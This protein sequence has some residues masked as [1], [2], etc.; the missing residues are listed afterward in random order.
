VIVSWAAFFINVKVL[1]PRIAVGFISLLTLN[2]MQGSFVGGLPSVPYLTWAEVFF[3]CHRFFMISQLFETS[4]ASFIC[5]NVSFRVGRRLDIFARIVVPLDYCLMIILLFA[6]GT[7]DAS[8]HERYKKLLNG[9]LIIVAINMLMLIATFVGWTVYNY[10][11]LAMRMRR[12][13]MALHRKTFNPPLDPNEAGMMFAAISDED[14]IAS[15][16]EL[17][18]Q[19]AEHS[20]VFT[21]EELLKELANLSPS[22]QPIADQVIPMALEC[23]KKRTIIANLRLIDANLFRIHFKVILDSLAVYMMR[24]EK[25]KSKG[26]NFMFRQKTSS[27]DG[28]KARTG[29][30]QVAPYAP[31]PQVQ[32]ALQSV[33]V[34]GAP[35]ATP[36]AAPEVDDE[37][38]AEE[39][40]EEGGKGAYEDIADPDSRADY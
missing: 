10:K 22:L 38:Q 15:W 12:D 36:A 27:I 18:R 5:D 28:G 34:Q 19:S 13:P 17:F 24:Q 35:S 23:L 2:N 14:D 1:M 21:L 25:A 40:E 7:A 39:Q 26:T 37:L 20:G 8:D 33:A 32:A 29:V 31:T 6:I 11:R 4:A 30:A 9:L 16:T 3:M